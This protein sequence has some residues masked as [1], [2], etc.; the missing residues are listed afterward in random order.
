M[1]YSGGNLVFWVMMPCS[2]V[3]GYQSLGGTC[4]LRLHGSSVWV[5]LFI[6]T[7][8][9]LPCLTTA[10]P[11]MLFLFS[12]LALAIVRSGFQT[13]PHVMWSEIRYPKLAMRCHTYSVQQTL[14]LSGLEATWFAH[15]CAWTSE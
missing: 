5:S 4:C 12:F 11:L 6:Y 15:L 13:L 7:Q 14:H 3:R 2:F 8:D 1:R 9:S 10:F